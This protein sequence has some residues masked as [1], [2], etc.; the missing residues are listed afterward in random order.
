MMRA[1]RRTVY[2]KNSSKADMGSPLKKYLGWSLRCARIR[3]RISVR[4]SQRLTQRLTKD[5]PKN[6]YTGCE[7]FHFSTEG[8]KKNWQEREREREREK[9]EKKRKKE[10]WSNLFLLSRLCVV[11]SGVPMPHVRITKEDRRVTGFPS[12]MG[13]RSC[14]LM[15]LKIFLPKSKPS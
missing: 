8:D 14:W 4:K 6:S 2:R 11:S 1:N 10:Q 7:I 3:R 15:E 9:G 12:K 13:T 5:P